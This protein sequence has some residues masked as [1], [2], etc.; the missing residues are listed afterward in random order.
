MIFVCCCGF[1]ICCYGRITQFINNNNKDAKNRAIN[2]N[3]KDVC[4]PY[5][6]FLTLKNNP[7]TYP[8][9]LKQ[10]KA[11]IYKLKLCSLA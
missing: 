10:L 3:K 1:V 9:T 11:N 6:P 4:V 8:I 7:K 2:N 5:R